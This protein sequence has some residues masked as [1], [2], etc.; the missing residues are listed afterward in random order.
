MRVGAGKG[1]ANG[2]YKNHGRKKTDRK[3]KKSIFSHKKTNWRGKL[4]VYRLSA[5]EISIEEQETERDSVK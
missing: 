3:K 1:Q 2:P 5:A 4:N